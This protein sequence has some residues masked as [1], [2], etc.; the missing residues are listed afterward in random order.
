MSAIFLRPTHMH[1]LP[2]IEEVIAGA[3]QALKNSGNPQWQDGQPTTAVELF[4]RTQGLN[5][6]VVPVIT[7]P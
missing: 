6:L 5:D 1:D 4:I 3:R 7:L 2:A